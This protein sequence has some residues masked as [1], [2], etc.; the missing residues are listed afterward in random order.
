M[1]RILIILANYD[2]KPSSTANCM[3]PL[4]NKLTDS[5]VVDIIT[6]RKDIDTPEYQLIDKV[7]IYRIDDYRIMNTIYL[8]KLKKINS[9]KLLKLLTKIMVN[10]LKAMYYIRYAKFSPEEG[11][12]GWEKN[13]VY[14][15][16]IELNRNNNYDLI[17]SVSQPFQ[18]HYIAEKIKDSR[19]ESIK[20]MVFEFDPF[21]YNNS[22]KVSKNKREKMLLDEKKVFQKCD[23]VILTPELFEFYKKNNYIEISDKVFSLPFSTLEEIQYDKR[24]VTKK[25]MTDEKINCLFTGQ[26]Y[27]DIRDPRTLLKLFSEI[28]GNIHLTMMTNFSEEKIKSYSSGDYIPS[29]IP[30]QNRDTALF[31]LEKADILVNIGNTVEFQTP[32]KIFEYMSTG[33]PII[34]FTKIKNDPVLNYLNLYTKKLIIKEWKIDRIDYISQIEKFCIENQSYKLEFSE[35]KE[36]LGVY[37]GSMVSERFMKITHKLLGES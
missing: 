8:N 2:P 5:Y 19:R 30:F 32:A 26:L 29:I 7:N 23:A 33:K 34:H 14:M 27:D 35:I 4:I 37:S 31:N 16:Y 36:A 24:N 20:W 3:K 21:A 22:I 28:N 25:F 18:S 9:V 12:G 10:T 13:R 15:K 17:V 11:T 1:K 6:D